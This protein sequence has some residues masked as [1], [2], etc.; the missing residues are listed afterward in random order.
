MTTPRPIPGVRL[1]AGLLATTVIVVASARIARPVVLRDDASPAAARPWPDMRIDV[2][3]A[4]AARLAALPGLGPA[5][6]ERVAA[7]RAAR[8]P[9]A[10]LDDL[11]RVPRIGPVTVERLAPFVIVGPAD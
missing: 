6:A 1:V 4:D 3:A 7:D 9:F 5:L 2:N 10:D 8:G 11:A